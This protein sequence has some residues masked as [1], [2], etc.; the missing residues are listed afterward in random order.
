MFREDQS[1]SPIELGAVSAET[2]GR[3]IG[4][5]EDQEGLF[6]TSTGLTDD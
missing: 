4:V 6:K 1:N 2:K 5:P 3:P